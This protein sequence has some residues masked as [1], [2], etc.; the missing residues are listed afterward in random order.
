ME[1][2]CVGCGRCIQVCPQGAISPGKTRMSADGTTAVIVPH[3]DR[4]KCVSCFT[5]AKACPAKSLYICGDEYSPEKLMERVRRERP[6]FERS[7]GGVTVSGGECLN[8]IDFLED[9]LKLC[10]AE[11]IHT[12]VDTT[13][14]AQYENIK[15]ILPYTDLF[16]YDLK[17]MDSELHKRFTGVPNE[18]I[19]DNAKKI[20]ADGGKLQVRIPIVP[21]FNDSDEMVREFGRFI[22]SLGK[23]AIDTVQ[24]LLY[25]KL[26]VVKWERLG[27]DPDIKDPIY[28]EVYVPTDERMHEIKD[29]L[30][31]EYD[32][33]VT[34]H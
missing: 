34:I 9:F 3:I 20:A 17:F 24:L 18:L 5:C 33:P 21:P 27:R 28:D 23:E 14:F 19:L 13:G 6:F 2:K 29:I 1:M 15:R 10:K 25:H 4:E 30:E 8:Q 26:G 7:S 31:K 16:L 22:A 11:G 32:L 12:A